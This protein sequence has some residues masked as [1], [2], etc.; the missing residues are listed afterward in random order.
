MN[1]EMNTECKSCGWGSE[2]PESH[3]LYCG[4]SRCEYIRNKYK[5]WINENGEM[6]A[7]LIEKEDNFEYVVKTWVYDKNT[8]ANEYAGLYEGAD[9]LK[10]WEDIADARTAFDSAIETGEFIA[11][12][13]IQ[14]DP[15]ANEDRETIIDDWEDN[16]LISA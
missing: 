2:Y 3:I 4:G 5:T 9:W 8:K 15:D 12:E 10:H 11:I 14:I 6:E 1:T 16:I 7:E 13:L